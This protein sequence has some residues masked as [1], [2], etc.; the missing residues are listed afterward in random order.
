[1]STFT[2]TLEEELCPSVPHAWEKGIWL[3]ELRVTDITLPKSTYQEQVITNPIAKM[4]GRKYSIKLSPTEIDV[5]DFIKGQETELGKMINKTLPELEKLTL[6]YTQ[7]FCIKW[8]RENNSE[9]YYILL[10]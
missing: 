9:A 7:K 2:I 5:Y 3:P 6:L 8:F 10:D 1:M 4:Q